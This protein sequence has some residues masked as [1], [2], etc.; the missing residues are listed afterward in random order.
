MIYRFELRRCEDDSIIIDNLEN[1]VGFNCADF[2]FDPTA[3]SDGVY[4]FVASAD[5]AG[6]FVYSE[7]QLS[8]TFRLEDSSANRAIVTDP[9]S[10]EIA[11]SLYLALYEF[12]EDTGI[13]GRV[14]QRVS[15]PTSCDS[16]TSSD[17]AFLDIFGSFHS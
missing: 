6:D 4:Y 17:L 11:D 2:E 3:D 12:D 9:S 5:E 7:G 8:A 16:S 14:L 15:F 13:R 1:L 10:I